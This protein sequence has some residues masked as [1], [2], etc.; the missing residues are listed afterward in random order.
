MP[1]V[2]VI[3]PAWNCA[4]WLPRCIRSVI[5]QTFHDWELIVVVQSDDG[6]AD[7]VRAFQRDDDRIVLIEQPNAGASGGRNR[8]IEAAHGAFV[9]F[10]DADDEFVPEKLARQLELFRL[11]P[12]LGLV[13]ADYAFVDLDGGFHPSVFDELAP[14]AR[15]VPAQQIAPRLF[16]CDENFFVHLAGTYF[17]ATIVGM[18]RRDVLADDLRFSTA[19][20]YAEEWLF[21]LQVARKTRVGF[22]DEPLCV[23]HHRAGSVTRTSRLANLTAQCATLRAIRRQFRD[24]PPAARRAIRLNLAGAC[25]HLAVEQ[26]RC[27]QHRKAVGTLFEACRAQLRFNTVRQCIASAICA[28]GM[29]GA[30][31]QK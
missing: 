18:V 5:A 14:A 6:S 20:T 22:V 13:Y 17:I 31:A 7:V 19:L 10:L 4:A 3:V 1:T 27:G 21:Y 24:A 26:Q 25:R 28:V 8:G 9:A 29:R 11:H 12:D 15:R 16:V 2:S 30:P 23:H